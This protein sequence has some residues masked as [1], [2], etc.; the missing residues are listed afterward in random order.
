LLAKL[1]LVGAP[2][3]RARSDL[4][5]GLTTGNPAVSVMVMDG[6]R[7]PAGREP[8]LPARGWYPDPEGRGLRWWDGAAWS[9]LALPPSGPPPPIPA[10]RV[11]AWLASPA[12][13]PLLTGVAVAT[14]IG[15]AAGVALLAAAIVTDRP[16]LPAIAIS[17]A[18][19]LAAAA[20]G[21]LAIALQAGR[22]NGTAQP[23]GTWLA[24]A[25]M[26]RAQ[27]R[28][29]R[30]GSG[31]SVSARWRRLTRRRRRALAALPR[32]VAWFYQAATW[33][34]FGIYVFAVV[35]RAPDPLQ[36]TAVCMM[37]MLAWSAIASRRLDRIR[38][39][40]ALIGTGRH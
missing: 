18:G 27:R 3:V 21:A 32:P 16:V 5:I 35:S 28:A 8:A 2:Q 33:P 14:A 29:L 6:S 36:G 31:R 34:T 20:N 22:R 39:E 19:F 1:D 26:R 23:G 25:A 17:V 7:E 11:S 24:L 37:T 9:Y 10:G 4:F 38:A 12:A 13:S 40:A 30:A 15:W